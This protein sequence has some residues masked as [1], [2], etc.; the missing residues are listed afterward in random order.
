MPG[1]L[2]EDVL[3]E[4]HVNRQRRRG[5]GGHAAGQD[6]QQFGARHPL[7]IGPDGRRRFDAEEECSTPPPAPRRR[8]TRGVL[9]NARPNRRNK[10]LDNAEVVQR[11]HH[12]GEEDYGGKD[13]GGEHDADRRLAGR[14]SCA[15][16]L[17]RE[18][19]E[20]E[21]MAPALPRSRT[22]ITTSLITSSSRRDSGEPEDRRRPWR[23]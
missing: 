11:R 13:L 17:M 3:E 14:R 18:G 12:R 16:G 23:S 19:T 4:Q 7:E 8:I 21:D 22:T 10:R 9:L 1:D 5:H 2:A 6:H 15:P 20:E